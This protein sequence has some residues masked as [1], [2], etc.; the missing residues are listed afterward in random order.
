M[1]PLKH[2]QVE[3]YYNISLYLGFILGLAAFIG[4]GI[5]IWK[6][7]F[8]SVNK[9][10]VISTGIVA[11]KTLFFMFPGL[12]LFIICV[13][14]MIYFANILKQEEY[15]KEVIRVNVGIKKDDPIFKQRCGCSDI[16]ELFINAQKPE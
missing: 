2:D 10:K 7:L 6:R 8:K 15:C 11:M 9:G 1:G 12:I 16:D 13:I 14:P 4:W 3:L 5:F